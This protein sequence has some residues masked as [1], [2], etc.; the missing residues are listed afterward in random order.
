MAK[1]IEYTNDQKNAMKASGTVLV[2]AAAGSGKTAILTERVARK[3][4]DKN[5]KISADRLLIVTFTNDA[6]FE[7]RSRITQNIDERCKQ[8][9]NNRYI[10]EQKILLQNAKICTIDSFCIALVRRYFSVLGISPDFMIADNATS[11]NITEK[12][13][14]IVLN[15]HYLAPE[16]DFNKLCNLFAAE[17]SDFQ[18]KS[19]I[20]DIYFSSECMSQPQKWFNQI[21]KSYNFS[22]L[23]ES[24][25][26][27]EVLKHIKNDL[28]ALLDIYKLL[29]NEMR[30]SAS[31]KA[32]ATLSD[33]IE[34]IKNMCSLADSCSWNALLNAAAQIPTFSKTFSKDKAIKDIIDFVNSKVKSVFGSINKRMVGEA[35]FVFNQLK[36]SKDICLMLVTLVKE[37]GAAYFEELLSKNC[38]TFGTVEQLALKLLCDEKDGVLVPSELSKEIS[39]EFD[40]VLVDEYQDNNDLQDSLF[41]ALS[42]SGKH[43]FFVGDVKQSIYGFRNASPENFIRYKESFEEYSEGSEKSKVLLK[44]NFRSKDSVCD[45]VNAFCTVVMQKETCSMNYTDEDILIPKAEYPETSA[46][47][48]ELLLN[49]FSSVNKKA[50]EVDA[51][52]VADYIERTMSE[53]N[54]IRESKTVLRAPRYSD[55][56][57][58]LRSPGNK[59][60]YYINALKEKGI[61]AV[62][63]SEKF[64]ETAEILTITEMLRT[65]SNPLS[66]ISLLSCLTS[67][68]FGFTADEI[69]EIRHKNKNVSLYSNVVLAAE[70]GNA[71]CKEFL[72]LLNYLRTISVTMSIS[73]LINEIYK[74]TSLIELFS[75]LPDGALRKQNLRR[76]IVLAESYETRD[77]ASLKGFIREIEKL[78]DKDFGNAESTSADCVK[79][80]SFHKSKGL[81]F[82]ICIVANLSG[83][84]NTMDFKNNYAF[85]QELG[86]GLKHII[87]E[88]SQKTETVA[89]NAI[90]SREKQKL[91]AEEI[92][93]LYVAMTRA[94]DRLVLSLSSNSL[95]KDI[96]NATVEL[97][98]LGLETGVAPVS[99][100]ISAS[101]Y[102]KWVLMT[103]LLKDK[104]GAIA[105]YADFS[106]FA[107]FGI[108]GFKVSIQD[109]SVF[110]NENFSIE[111]AEKEKLVLDTTVD[112]SKVKEKF[113]YQYPNINET[114][115]PSKVS[116]T[117]LIKGDDN[118][119]YFSEKPEFISKAGLTPAE[120]GTAAHKFM[121]FADYNAA[122]N[123]LEAELLRLKEWEFLSE[124]EAD[125]I[126]TDK[127]KKFFNSSVFAR[128]AAA[129]KVYREYKFMIEYPYMESK[130]IAQGIADCVF[131]ENGK[132]VILDFKTDNVKSAD[133]L[134]ARYSEQLK[135]YSYALSRIFDM[136][137]KESIL[138]SLKLG[139]EVRVS[140]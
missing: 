71:R 129:D 121:Q 24:S 138:F 59:A 17:R 116:V 64:T 36:E 47:S 45:F 123:D 111:N 107:I 86:L 56:T 127:L 42:D 6:A 131:I 66:D 79:I 105:N 75:A 5:S 37:F 33:N 109:P 122:K 120:R 51:K 27:Q 104:S 99:S 52:A 10:L 132:L 83:Q 115:V 54:I 85:N 106:P 25:Y 13:L 70:N 130:T 58:L 61:P 119:F 114:V 4:C 92:R 49:D 2:S 91:I 8:E 95:K 28:L 31:D 40:E 76:F 60:D 113:D 136:P 62:F 73:R 32:V 53:G 57:I 128:I 108:D 16:P 30:D 94:E 133:E 1:V 15:K 9:P 38:L 101:S 48:V 21:E 81:Q 35:D 29:S 77:S 82:P 96:T 102:A 90:I 12:A 44:S 137:V 19:A 67:V 63:N 78:N 110:E 126:E 98:S 65:I 134:V 14:E 117:E 125:A 22:E 3:I 74:K 7:L 41:F 135:I 46:P 23:E 68:V 139:E 100:V 80:L 69:V 72:D 43:L 20:K 84:F 50:I 18:L 34:K 88:S 55:F 11:E 118:S 93:L 103:A 140:E 89:F 124:A 39:S 87:E 112:F 97:G 26:A